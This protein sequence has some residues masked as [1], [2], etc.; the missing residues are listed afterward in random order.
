MK[1]VD[2]EK[3]YILQ[4]YK[5]NPIEINKCN[6]KF[7]WDNSGKKYLDLFSGISVNNLGH[8]NKK[9]SAAI[10]TQLSKYI[11][12]SNLYYAKPQAELA[13][14]L[15]ELSFPGVVFL[16][17]SG[18]EANECAIKLARKYGY[19]KGK[20]EIISFKNSFHGRTIATLSATGQEK[21][22]KNFDVL[23][24]FKFAQYNN[25]ESVKKLINKKT[26]AV[27]IEPVL[28]EGGVVPAKKEFLKEL[29]VLCDKNGLILIFDEIQTGIG[30][31][32]NVFAF[33][34]FGV[35][36]DVFTLAKGL[37]G[38]LPLGATVIG[39]KYAN[40]LTFG[41][42]GSTFGGN[43]VSCSASKAVL[44]VLDAK[45]LSNIK[46]LGKYFLAKLVELKGKHKSIVDARGV[47]LMLGLELTMPCAEIVLKCAKEGF[48]INCIQ[49][50]VLRFLP[51]FIINKSDIDKFIIKLDKI[52]KGLKK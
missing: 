35:A 14:K 32:G 33:K 31:T 20:N 9:V 30:R 1:T 4:T 18:A 34:H 52:L 27:I 7:V 13:Q 24:G 11:H 50:N 37:A 26:V 46:E 41:D 29:K 40:V 36:P 45:M 3:K 25:I 43:P 42:H 47:G 44:E 38:G 51:P 19:A 16:S 22:H 5:R 28:G 17:N 23:P 39:K 6:G 15:I 2:L 48:L 10:K 21:F 8:Q 12:V 49:E